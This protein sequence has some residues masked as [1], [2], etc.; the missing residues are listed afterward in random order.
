MGVFPAAKTSALVSK[1]FTLMND[2]LLSFH[3]IVRADSKA[4]FAYLP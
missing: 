3:K 4:P 1:T 2:T